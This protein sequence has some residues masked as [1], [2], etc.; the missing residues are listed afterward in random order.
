MQ[1]FNLS[2]SHYRYVHYSSDIV[3]YVLGLAVRYTSKGSVDSCSRP[4]GSSNY[5]VEIKFALNFHVFL[6]YTV[7]T[8]YTYYCS[9]HC[10]PQDI[11]I[12]RISPTQGSFCTV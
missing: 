7:Y 2:H 11:G 6:Y 3:Y 1:Y 5:L 12:P 10:S 4:H 9:G 8:D